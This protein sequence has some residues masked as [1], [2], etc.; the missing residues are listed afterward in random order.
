MTPRRPLFLCL[1][2]LLSFVAPSLRAEDAPAENEAT[3]AAPQPSKPAKKK[4]AKKKAYDY[5]RS[6]YKSRE[7]AQTL[8]YKFNEKGEPIS[9]DSKKKASVKKK[10]RSEP[11]EA[12]LNEPAACGAEGGCA[13]KK[14]EADAL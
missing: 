5:E 9:A 10:K 11:P 8:N 4:A 1:S 13:E 14:T 3:E 12:D 6:K 2:L 7:F